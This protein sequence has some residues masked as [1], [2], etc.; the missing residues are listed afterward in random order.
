MSYNLDLFNQLPHEL[1]Q[2]LNDTISAGPTSLLDVKDSVRVATTANITLSGLQTIDGVILVS[3][4]RVLVKNQ[5]TGSQNG[6]YDVSDVAWTRSEDANTTENVKP[7][8]FTFVQEG[9]ANGDSGWILTTNAPITLNTTSLT[10]SQFTG[11]GGIT[12]GDGITLTG[13]NTVNVDPTVVRTT[14]TLTAGAGLTGGG[15]FSA[16]RTV[17][18]IANADGSIT[19]NANDIQVG[20]LATDAQHGTRGGG[21]QHSA[22]TGLS[23]GFM[24]A[25]DKTKLD[26]IESGAQ[27]TS[28]ARVQTALAGATSSVTLNSQK[29]SSVA[30]PTLAQDAATKN[31]VDLQA[32]GEVPSARTITAGAGLTG[33]G[34]LSVN[35]TLDIAA[36]AD[37]SI[38][39]NAN[40]IQVGILATDAQ[41]G[42]RGGGTQHD[43]V[44]AAGAAGFMSGSDKSKLDGIETGAQ[45]TT[46]A[47]VQSALSG[48]TS[49]VAFN[50]QK[51]SGVADPTLAQD[52]ATKNY[53]DTQAAGEVPAARIITAGAGLTGGGNLSADRTFDVVANA[54]GSITVN[55]NDIQVGILATDAQHGT[56]G[57]GTQHSVAIA[58]TS[59]GFISATSQSKVDGLP[60][61]VTT[62]KTSAYSA[63]IGDLVRAN[64]TGGGFT[65]TLPAIAAANS[66][67]H[68]T[69]K[70]TSLSVNTLT[71]A[72]TGANTIDGSTLTTIT[73]A[74]GALDFVSDGA[75][76]WM[77]L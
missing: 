32:A 69:V 58:G 19:V 28:F 51:L 47:H 29:L 48:A 13:G 22:A 61:T 6:I 65:I 17:D 49:A 74:F 25:A 10:F 57:G 11:T 35:R 54:D 75:G 18:I 40:D 7:N 12:A 27:V 5:T 72:P 70:N 37:G 16:N 71:I 14:R 77:V 66:G 60:F 34:D 64:P 33:G 9:T 8:L 24:A 76:N 68:I 42:T 62:V 67:Q 31:Y 73:S 15:D 59:A 26:G 1:R 23:A 44:I 56:R 2:L 38:T 21:T 30:D 55:A 41:H 50:S 4:N 20:V 36:N 39:V 43:A 3:T 52:A 63:V 45:A 53:V 46:F